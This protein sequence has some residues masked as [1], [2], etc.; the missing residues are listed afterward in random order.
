MSEISRMEYKDIV[1]MLLSPDPEKVMRG[2]YWYCML[3]LCNIRTT[4]EIHDMTHREAQDEVLTTALR[5]MERDLAD[6]LDNLS[7]IAT[8]MHVDLGV[9]GEQPS[10]V[11][12][13]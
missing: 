2:E 3:R 9:H 10:D 11:S 5:N 1:A 13:A 4:L 6:L 7:I 12:D 8:I